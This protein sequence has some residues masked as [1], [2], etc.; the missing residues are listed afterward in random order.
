MLKCRYTKPLKAVTH[1]SDTRDNL[2]SLHDTLKIKENKNK[3]KMNKEI[4][5]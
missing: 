4:N 3:M 2:F 5:K 1:I